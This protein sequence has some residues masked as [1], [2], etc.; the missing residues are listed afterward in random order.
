M[1]DVEIVGLP[2]AITG[3]FGTALGLSFRLVS[4]GDL[5]TGA[6]VTVSYGQRSATAAADADGRVTAQLSYLPV[7]STSVHLSYPG[8]A[9]HRPAA[10]TVAV[11]VTRQPTII[12][13]LTVSARTPASGRSVVVGFV[14]SSGGDPASRQ[15]ATISAGGSTFRVTLDDKG[16]GSATIT[17]LPVGTNRIVV[18]YPGDE[19]REGASATVSVTVTEPGAPPAAATTSSPK[20]AAPSGPCPSYARACVDLTNSTSWLQSGGKVSY[21]PVPIT[22]GRP[23]YRTRPGVF[24]VFWKDKNHRSSLFNGAPMPNS[25]FFDGGIAFHAG[26]LT[27]W[28]HGCIHLSQAASQVYW[29]AIRNGDKVAV[30]GF[31]PY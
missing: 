1:A 3:T 23:G 20:A 17:D 10:A 14:V 22:S 8:D 18:R 28:S 2:P 21:G 7:G 19:T 5:P 16:H 27:A 13:N 26:S 29:D 24:S 31:A 9:G 6:A 25:I 11:T 15:P 12:R 30:F 4:S